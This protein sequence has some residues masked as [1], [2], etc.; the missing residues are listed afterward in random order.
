M[1]KPACGIIPEE[2]KIISSRNEFNHAEVST[3][4]EG[5]EKPQKKRDIKQLVAVIPPASQLMRR[6]GPKV[7]EKRIRV[8]LKDNV[9]PNELH[10]PPSLAK[11]IGVKERVELSVPGKKRM[12][13][14]PVLNESIPEN[15]VWVNTEVMREKG[16]ADN[17]LATVRG[18]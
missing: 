1:L 5:E 4:S 14:K 12:S 11:F 15:E 18:A 17:S 7:R 2:G 10:L 8:R 3:L 16:V 6:E 13:F 9:P